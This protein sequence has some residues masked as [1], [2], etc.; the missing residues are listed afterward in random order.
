MNPQVSPA[1]GS[2]SLRS[3]HSNPQIALLL[4]DKSIVTTRPIIIGNWKMNGVLTALQDLSVVA[5]HPAVGRSVRVGVA[6]PATLIALAKALGKIEIGAQDLHPEDAGAHTGSLSGMML[7]D[8]GA[9]FTLVGHSEC[10]GSAGDSDETV[11]AKIA[12]AWRNHLGV[13]LCVGETSLQ[14]AEG[15][16]YA[17]IREQ[18][19]A[20]PTFITNELIVAY[21]PIWCIGAPQAAEPQ[22]IADMFTMIRSE[23]THRFGDDGASWPLLYGG[24]VNSENVQQIIALD[25]VDGVL[26]SRACLSASTFQDLIEACEP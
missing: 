20:I 5:N 12:A 3:A 7:H 15:R 13:V 2:G 19:R 1:T 16:S 23:L 18:L 6:L 22:D 24:A 21:E 14:R 8:A 26:A 25:Q 11:S 10:R 17:A 4:L 9:R